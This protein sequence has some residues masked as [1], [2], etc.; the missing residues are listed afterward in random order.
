V[1]FPP[2]EAAQWLARHGPQPSGQQCAAAFPS[3]T[4][5]VTLAELYA[6][7]S[8]RLAASEAGCHPESTG[9]YL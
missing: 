7:R 4:S 2:A 3:V 8:G 5:P 9:Q 1:P 6:L